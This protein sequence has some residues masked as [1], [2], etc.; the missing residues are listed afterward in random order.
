MKIQKDLLLMR[1]KI[2]NETMKDQIKLLELT[3]NL[4]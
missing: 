1:I 4:D 2:A 3:E